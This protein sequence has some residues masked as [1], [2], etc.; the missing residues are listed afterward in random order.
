MKGNHFHFPII[1]VRVWII[2]QTFLATGESHIHSY[3]NKTIVLKNRGFIFRSD[4]NTE[5]LEGFA[6]AGLFDSVPIT[7]HEV[8]NMSY[9]KNDIFTNDTFVKSLI[10]NIAQ[11]GIEVENIYQYPQDIEGVLYQN[12]FYIVQTRPQ[13]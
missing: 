3:P 1:K 13:V 8:I 11:L 9:H 7:E 12:Q 4:S 10:K 5:D 6:G 2:K